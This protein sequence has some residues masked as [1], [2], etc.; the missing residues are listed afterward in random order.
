MTLQR[1]DGVQVRHIPEILAF[2]S[3]RGS[4]DYHIWGFEEPENSLELAAAIH[5]ANR[6]LEFSKSSN[7][8]IFLTSHS[9]AFFRLDQDGLKKYF[10]SKK[11]PEGYAKPIST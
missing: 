10:V 2:L 11:S 4:E 1:G 3:D 5:E 6:F 9:P 8:Q 7:K